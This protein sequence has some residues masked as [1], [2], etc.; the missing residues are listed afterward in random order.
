MQ[1]NKRIYDDAECRMMIRVYD[2][3]VMAV[4]NKR[5]LIN[6]SHLGGEHDTSTS[7]ASLIRIT[8]NRNPRKIKINST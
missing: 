7:P 4:L 2:S 1:H 8:E 6:I 3:R 5:L